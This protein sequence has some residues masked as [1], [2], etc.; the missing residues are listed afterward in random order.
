MLRQAIVDMCAKLGDAPIFLVE[1]HTSAARAYAGLGGATQPQQPLGAD[2]ARLIC[3][4]VNG[5]L[6][7]GMAA[8]LHRPLA[9]SKK[10]IKGLQVSAHTCAPPSAY[11]ACAA[12]TRWLQSCRSSTALEHLYIACT[13]I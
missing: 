8:M 12:C 3:E 13:Y 5:Q 7:I 10:L 6:F 1:P 4:L 2:D 11:P 9:G